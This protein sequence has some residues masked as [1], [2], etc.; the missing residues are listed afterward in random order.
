M[1]RPGPRRR[2]PD[3][4]VMELFDVAG[5]SPIPCEKC[6]CVAL[7]TAHRIQRL[8]AGARGFWIKGGTDDHEESN[9]SE[10]NEATREESEVV[11]SKKKGKEKMVTPWPEG[12]PSKEV[13]AVN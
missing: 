7:R 10:K 3:A 9:A 6:N 1:A 8:K 5:V 12:N 11:F 2:R 13:C 4:K